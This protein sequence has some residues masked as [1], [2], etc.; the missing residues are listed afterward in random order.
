MRKYIGLLFSLHL[1]Y[2][3]AFSQLWTV[4]FNGTGNGDDA[5]KSM[6][7]D[8]AG[9]VYE[10]G[11]SYS[12]G[13]NY[14]YITIKYN[15]SGVQQW[16]AR[17]N[18]PPA[19]GTDQANAVFVDNAGNVYV[20]GYSYQQAFYGNMDIATVKYN[21]QGIQQWVARFDG[22]LHRADAGT[23]IKADASGNVYV[24]GWTTDTH[25]SY[26]RKDYVIIKYN[27]SGVQQ[28]VSTYN[29]PGNKDDTPAGLGLD[30]AGNVYVTGTS[31]AGEYTGKNDLLTIKYNP[32]GVQQWQ[33]RYNSVVNGYDYS[34]AIAVDNSGNTYVTG[35]ALGDGTDQNYVTIKYDASGSQVWVKS[36]DGP[37]HGYDIA[38][39]IALDNSGNVYVTGESQSA[40]FKTDY[41]TVKYNSAGV[42][43]WT[44]RYNGTANDNDVANTLAVDASGN[45]YVTGCIN[46]L[47][48]NWDVATVKYSSTG[49]QQWVKRYDGPGHK[50]DNGIAVGVDVAG[51]VYIAGSST[52]ASS[53]SDFFTIKYGPATTGNKSLPTEE[54]PLLITPVKFNLQNYPNPFRTSTEIGF[55]IPSD[56]VVKLAIYD[57]RGIEVAVLVNGE[58]KKGNYTVQWIPGKLPAG[59]YFYKLLSGRFESRG[60][61][62]L[63]K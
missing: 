59:S 24:A 46:G 5:I 1:F 18:G 23:A 38:H 21:A 44:T 8:N 30:A 12:G 29:G 53:G 47:I 27:S 39:A 57:V 7:T 28:W 14:D 36:Y 11:Y 49:I 54:N 31:Y 34:N 33:A 41:C 35:A 40:S 51:N 63:I 61:M 20:T 16:Q 32:Q 42:Q 55:S 17:Y 19:T 2:G 60:K 58:L 56:R 15:S 9:N 10:T 43:Q 3:I 52:G 45:V 22:V 48:D 62:I 6:V 25:A 50:S 4:R 26:A 13:S 37:G